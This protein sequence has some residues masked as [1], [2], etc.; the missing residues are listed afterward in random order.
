MKTY[1]AAIIGCGRMGAFID[2]E[3]VGEPGVVFPYSHAGGYSSSDRTQLVACS[4]FRE[5][6]MEAVGDKYDIPRERQYTDYLEMVDKEELDI[7]SVTTHVEHHSKIVIDLANA[8]VKAIFC[9]KGLA[10]SLY[11]ANQM[12][13][14][15][16]RNGTI[17]N[18]GAQRRYHPGFSKMKE[19]IDSGEL[20]S[21]QS[22]VITYSAGLF[23]HGCHVVDLALYLAGDPHAVWVQG[24]APTSDELKDGDIYKDDPGGDG[25]VQLDN[26]IT[27]YFL[28]T[29]RYEYQ[30][31]CENGTLGTMR[32]TLG[33]FMRK[34]QPRGLEEVQ[35]PGF[36]PAS[37]TVNLIE[38]LAKSL[39]S[40]SPPLGGIESARHG[41]EI[42]VAI[43]ESH[44]QNGRRIEMPLKDSSL[45]MTRSDRN[46]W[47][48][49]LRWR[50]PKLS[51]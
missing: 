15:C 19:I 23:D 1:N 45:R 18:L 8:G 35:Y 49:G 46:S 36:E 20:G 12:A 2:N 50:E 16:E 29:N 51:V 7:V 21:V 32:D 34:G 30:V 24:H 43:L 5:D 37:S 31:N 17:L 48:K 27:I 9:E 42:M 3:V 6:L 25:V 33:W 40:G 11:E 38:D 39:D 28:H 41:V 13:E 44:L 26:G 4:D 22:M 14:A 10:P 47:Q